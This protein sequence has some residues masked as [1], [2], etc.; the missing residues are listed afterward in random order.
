MR[1]L[2]ARWNLSVEAD[3]PLSPVR[4]EGRRLVAL[5]LLARCERAREEPED[6]AGPS[7]S[8]VRIGGTPGGC[9]PLT[10][11]EERGLGGTPATVRLRMRPTAQHRWLPRQ[12]RRR[13]RAAGT[14]P[15]A[16]LAVTVRRGCLSWGA[17]RP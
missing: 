3:A 4:A 10:P 6:L 8:A 12:P 5:T 14:G 16:R 17:R 1:H 9:S 15:G 11:S 13:G 7:V 2:G